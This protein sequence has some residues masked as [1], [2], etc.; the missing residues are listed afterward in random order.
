VSCPESRFRA[1]G[2]CDWSGVGLF[3]GEELLVTNAD[4]IA[5]VVA[6]CWDALVAAR[7]VEALGLGLEQAGFQ[8]DRL[9]AE[10]DCALFQKFKEPV[11]DAFATTG[12]GDIHPL[13]LGGVVVNSA[14]RCTTDR[15]AAKTG[16]EEDRP[17]CGSF[18]RGKGTWRGTVSPGQFCAKI[19][20]ERPGCFANGVIRSDSQSGFVGGH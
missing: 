11:R 5:D 19:V 10:F 4:G 7:F 17:W 6:E 9:I 15:L 8:T 3:G 1:G 12:G 13:D 14:E 2:I 16:H 20:D 18:G